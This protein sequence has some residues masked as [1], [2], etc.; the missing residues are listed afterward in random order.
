ML[1]FVIVEI[2]NTDR[3]DVTFLVSLLQQTVT[4]HVIAVAPM[5][6]MPVSPRWYPTTM[7]STRL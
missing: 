6:A 2:G 7:V 3:F 5:A 1:Q 4:C